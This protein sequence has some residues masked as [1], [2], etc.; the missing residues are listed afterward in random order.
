MN[1]PRA[2]T[3]VRELRPGSPAYEAGYRYL[4]RPTPAEMCRLFGHVYAGN[5]SVLG[6]AKVKCSRCGALSAIA[7]Q[8][9][10]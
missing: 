9:G 1:D 7:N 5:E 2:S 8:K 10:T 3:D 6:W 4:T